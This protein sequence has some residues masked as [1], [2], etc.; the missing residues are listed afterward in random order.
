M[1]AAEILVGKGKN[2]TVQSVA[3]TAPSAPGI[4]AFSDAN[5]DAYFSS[6]NPLGGVYVAG[7]GVTVTVTGQNAG[8][9]MTV[10][11]VNPPA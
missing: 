2:Q 6:A 4:P 3:A 11:V 9:T 8:G 10:Q 5:P 1:A 7:H